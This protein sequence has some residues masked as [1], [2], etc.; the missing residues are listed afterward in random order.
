MYCIG[1]P[2]VE[3]RVGYR[4]R[5]KA[6][7]CAD[8]LFVTTTSVSVG[9]WFEDESTRLVWVEDVHCCLSKQT[10]RPKRYMDKKLTRKYEFEAKT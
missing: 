5:C 9:N 7:L 2:W 10:S 1:M 3:K 8:A 4:A 6:R